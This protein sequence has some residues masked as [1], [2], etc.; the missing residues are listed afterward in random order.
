M[1]KILIISQHYY[2]ENFRITDIAET[3]VKYG[4]EVTVI[5]GY[6][7]Y[8]EGNIYEGYYGKG[9]KLHS[10]EI[11]NGVN[12]C[13][14]Y[15][16]PRK[17]N[18]IDLFL[19][20]YS[21]SY[22]MKRRVKKLKGDFD[23]VFINQLSPVM[24]SWAGIDYAKKH[25]IPCFLYCYDLWPDSLAAGGIKKKSVIYKYYDR[26]SRN[27]YKK[28]DHI[29]VTSKLFVDYFINHHGIEEKNISYLP[30]YCED[31]FAP[32]TKNEDSIY[33]FVFAGNIGKIQSVET[34]IKAANL[35]KNFNDI[36][37]HIVGDGS[38]LEECKKLADELKLENVIFYGKRP[39]DE[40]PFFYNM[41]SAMLVTLKDDDVISN[42]LPGKVQSYMASKKPIIASI[43]G[44]TK[45]VIEHS[46]CGLCCRA[47]D[48]ENLAKLLV[49]F[50]N[51]DSEE[52]GNNSYDFYVNNFTK[53]L[54]FKKLL[55]KWREML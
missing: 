29:F 54:F 33:N 43:N 14:C 37:I 21:I 30:Q 40:M 3:L 39:L 4:N 49:G 55:S 41:A 6:P 8:P 17:K 20:Y 26:I 42:T 23:L 48:Y 1:F 22:S 50:R 13:R 52:M 27:I 46:K 35:V 11:I 47:E 51:Y 7:N 32:G 5:C 18:F 12:V 15:E 9:H 31:I 44:E 25:K 36:K 53:D 34:I 38:N 16:H 10:N 2:P 24:Q 45:F 28:V 19:N